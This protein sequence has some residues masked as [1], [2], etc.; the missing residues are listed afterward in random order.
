MIKKQDFIE[1]EYTG[2]LKEGM[3][4]DTTDKEIAKANNIYNEKT[5]FCPVV[6]CVGEQQIIKGL[7][8]NIIGKELGSYTINLSPEEAFGKKSAK[9]IQLIS[10]SKFKQQNVM[11]MPGLQ[12]NID[13]LIGIVK[14]VSGGRTLVDFNHPLAGKDVVYQ[15]KINKII[16]DNKEKVKSYIKISLNTDAEVDIENNKAKINLKKD[17][18][19]EIQ[20]KIAQKLKELT[21][22]ADFDFKITKIHKK[23]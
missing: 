9:L 4:F 22:I 14:T 1:L 7:D 12:V 15:I 21:N 13:G 10:T 17:I 20:A 5:E 6:I 23:V 2:K 3:V 18:P 8:K 19:K 16:T 11:P